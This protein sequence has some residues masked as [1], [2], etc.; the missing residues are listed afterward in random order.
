MPIY[1]ATLKKTKL[2]HSKSEKTKGPDM[3]YMQF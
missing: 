3:K 1:C 2:T